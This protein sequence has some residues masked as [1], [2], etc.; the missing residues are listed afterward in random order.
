M[1]EEFDRVRRTLLEWGMN[2]HT[3]EGP[4]SW[5]CEY[6]DIYGECDCLDGLTNDILRS[7]DK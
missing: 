7:L 3:N 5:R 6:P 2:E 4:H 1:S